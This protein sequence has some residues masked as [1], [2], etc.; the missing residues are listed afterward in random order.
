MRVHGCGH[1]STCMKSH[2]L[3]R[4]RGR[5]GSLRITVKDMCMCGVDLCEPERAEGWGRQIAG[6]TMPLVA[7][8]FPTRAEGFGPFPWDPVGAEVTQLGPAQPSTYRPPSEPPCGV[9][10][11]QGPHAPVTGLPECLA[12]RDQPQPKPWPGPPLGPPLTAR[13]RSPHPHLPGTAGS[14]EK[15]F[16]RSCVLTPTG[17]GQPILLI[18]PQKQGVRR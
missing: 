1:A 10:G 17:P 9:S 5:H 3:L 16:P 6:V 7:K 11:A 2:V 15:G 4:T 18:T 13:Q 14:T 8:L 12:L